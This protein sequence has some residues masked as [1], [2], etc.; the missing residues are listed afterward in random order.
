MGRT[1][2][3]THPRCPRKRVKPKPTLPVVGIDASSSKCLLTL[4][5]DDGS[6]DSSTAIKRAVGS[7]LGF[8]RCA[9]A[10]H[11]SSAVVDRPPCD[12]LSRRH[13]KGQRQSCFRSGGGGDEAASESHPVV[14]VDQLDWAD[15]RPPDGFRDVG[16]SVPAWKV[17]CSFLKLALDTLKMG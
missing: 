15:A 3:T 5:S 12:A 17:I 6:D 8:G 13:S 7:V 9:L 2:H 1:P 4:S 10:G 14:L 11:P 16:Y